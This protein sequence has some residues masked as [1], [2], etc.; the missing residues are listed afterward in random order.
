MVQREFAPNATLTVRRAF[1]PG[2]VGRNYEYRYNEN[3]SMTEMV[4]QDLN[5]TTRMAYDAAERETLVDETW[6]AGRDTKTSYDVGGNVAERRTDGTLDSGSA[7]DGGRT[8]TYRYDPLDRETEMAVA[9]PNESAN[10]YLTAYHPSGEVKSQ[11]RPSSVDEQTFYRTDG[12]V[13]QMRSGPSGGDR[14]KDQAYAYDRNLNRTSDERGTHAFNARDQLVSWT[15]AAGQP[16]AG[17]T[18]RYELD[19]TGQIT[20][21]DDA[22]QVTTSRHNG[23]RLLS[24]TTEVSAQPNTTRRFAYDDLGAIVEET[25]QVGSSAPTSEVRY[26]YDAFE[27][28]VQARGP[29]ASDDAFYRHDGL[30]RRD[31]KVEGSATRDFSYVGMTEELSR[32]QDAGETRLYDYDS[33][34]ERE[35]MSAKGASTSH[36]TYQKDANGSVEALEGKG[37]TVAAN[38]RYTYDPY[39]ESQGAQAALG[40]PAKSNPFRY[41]GFYYDSGIKIY[42]MQ[43]RQYRPDIGRFLTQDRY[44]S[45]SGDFNLQSDPLTQNRYAFAGGNPVSRVEW[46]GHRPRCSVKLIGPRAGSL[47]PT[48]ASRNYR[49]GLAVRARVRCSRQLI[50]PEVRLRLRYRHTPPVF[51]TSNPIQDGE[52]PF[53]IRGGTRRKNCSRYQ[54]ICNLR[55]TFGLNVQCGSLPNGN[56]R[57]RLFGSYSRGG[58]RIGFHTGPLFRVLPFSCG[59]GRRTGSSVADKLIKQIGR[60]RIR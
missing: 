40:A 34:G 19:G 52:R 38:N 18:V 23:D 29:D 5:R 58:D 53:P 41:E 21:E 30:D 45:S 7:Y 15:R 44:E 22:G 33:S 36:W 11:R 6:S 42:D 32:E 56:L 59:G 10:T 17:K 26:A 39:G 60:G 13:S 14:T 37:A 12:N 1:K 9:E 2:S 25:E 28:L 20:R 27:R 3:H 49:L 47:R 4:D 16:G 31:Q 57:V 55:F 24:Q 35:G 50:A 54:N 43:A 51:G 48:N 46:D 8:T